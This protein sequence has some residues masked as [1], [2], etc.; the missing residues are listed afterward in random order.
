MKK[1]LVEVGVTDDTECPHC[2][3]ESAMSDYESRAEFKPTYFQHDGAYLY[4]K[5]CPLCGWSEYEDYKPTEEEEESE[6]WPDDPFVEAEPSNE[7]IRISKS[8]QNLLSKAPDSADEALFEYIWSNHDPE[9]DNIDD[10]KRGF[11]ELVLS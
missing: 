10:F 3:F 2:G 5:Y 11:L 4:N 8:I 1:Y 9:K 7:Q 6:D